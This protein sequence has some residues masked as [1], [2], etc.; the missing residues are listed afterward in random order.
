[1]IYVYPADETGCG[2]YRLIW[3]AQVLQHAG[4]AVRVILK[5][6]VGNHFQ[7]KMIGN[8]MVDVV[9]PSDASVV[10]LQRPTHKFLHQAVPLI[11][12]KG[13]AVV[14]DMDDDLTTIDPRNPAFSILHPTFGGTEHSW[15]YALP[16]CDLAT[17][18]TVSTPALLDVYARRTRGV[19][20]PNYVPKSFTEIEHVD[21]DVVGWGGSIHSH[22]DDLQAMG[23]AITRLSRELGSFTIVGPEKGVSNIFNSTVIQRINV[24]G[25]VDFL[26]WANAL[27]KHLGIGVAPISDTKF[28]QSKSWLKPLE[29]ASLGIPPISSHRPEY[30]SLHRAGIGWIAY[31]PKDWYRSAMRLAR[32]ESLRQELSV[33]WRQKVAEKFT[34]EQNAHRWLNA[35]NLA[36][37]LEHS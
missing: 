36:L 31:T 14:I 5:K 18:V 24:T 27:T 3:P 4:V 29:Y 37:Q 7:G 8:T 16:A 21:S 34:I 2:Y 6:D 11:R 15:K 28:N 12:K 32:N 19:V 17:L 25:S 22:P 9:I 1:M 20:L 35:W 10:V 26:D 30:E 13:V 23:P 33:D